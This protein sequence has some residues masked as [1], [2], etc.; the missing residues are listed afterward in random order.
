[1]FKEI[2]NKYGLKYEDLNAAEKQTL[3]EMSKTYQVKDLTVVDIREAIDAMIESL[4]KELVSYETPAGLIAF[5]F[6]KKRRIHVEARLHNYLM[7]RELLAG[8]ERARKAVERM[9][10]N[11]KK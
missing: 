2:L 4:T 3:E 9:L 1:M 10:Q 11:I 8:P 7:L 5:L 6:R